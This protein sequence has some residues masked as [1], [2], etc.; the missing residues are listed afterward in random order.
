MSGSRPSV[1]IRISA[2]GAEQA[3]RQIEAIGPAG[4]A[5]MRRVATATS[6]ATPPVQNLARASDAATRALAGMGGSLGTLGGAL[7]GAT[8]AA[9]G[10]ST[11]LFAVGAAAATGLTAAIQVAEK[12]ERLSL[13]TEAIVRATGGAAGVS[14]TEIRT[15]SQ[16][17]A[18][19][20]LASTAGVEE[21]A[22]KLL[23]F[24]NVAGQTFE[25][26]LKAAQDLAAVGFG[27]IESASVQLG[28]AL[29]N[30]AEGLSA[31]TRIGVSFSGAQKEVIEQLVA[32]G[33]AAEA[34]AV[35][36]EAVEKQVGGAGNAEAGGLAGAYDTLGQN[37]QEFLLI[38]GNTG[39]LQAA[40][41]A[42]NILAGAIGA[43]NKAVGPETAL[44][45]AERGSAVA[46]EQAA[47]LR[48]RMQAAE[49]DVRMYMSSGLTREQAIS[50]AAPTAPGDMSGGLAKQLAEAE[51]AVVE[52]NQRLFEARQEH[53]DRMMLADERARA[54]AL[55]RDRDAA[56]SAL[57]QHRLRHDKEFAAKQAHEKE[58]AALNEWRRTG[59][60][61][62][63]EFTQMEAEAN[64]RL[65][66]AL[67]GTARAH[68]RVA[69]EAADA[70]AHVKT[71]LKAQEKAAE[72]VAKAQ[73][74]AAREIERFHERSFDA[75]ASIGE[76]AMDRLGDAMVDAF[77]KG[78]GAA[79]NFGNVARSIAA[80]V[81]TDFAKLALINPMLNS[82]FVSSSGARPTL[83]GAFGGG[84][85]SIG[86]IG[87]ML[88]LSGLLP[89]GGLGGM[90]ASANSYLFGT[91]AGPLAEVT[92]GLLGS[93]GSMSLGALGAGFGSGMFVNS[94]LGGNQVGGAV[95]SGLGSAAG[96]ALGSLVGMPFL[97]ALLG[98]GLGGGLGGMIGPKPSV[99]AWGYWLESQDGQLA[100]INRQYY[101]EAGAQQFAYA[102]QQ[103]AAT[104]AMLQA[105]GL[106]VSGSRNVGGNKNGPDGRWG[107]AGSFEEA[108]ADLRFSATD[109]AHLDS[110]L[111][112]RS[113]AGAQALAEFVEGFRAIE[114]VIKGLTSD[115]IPGFTA[116]I[117]AVNDNFAA[118][119]EEATRLGA[120]MDGL[121][122]AQLRAITEIEDART[123][124][125]RSSVMSLEVRRMRA[126]GETEQ[127]ELLAQ[128]EAANA[129]IRSFT[130]SLDSLA[131][132]AEDKAN[133]LLQL[134][135][136]Q[137]AE[138]AAI[139]AR[140]GEQAN[141]ALRRGLQSGES[142]M[143][144]LAFGAAS[145]LA[146]EQQYFAAMTTLNQARQALESGGSLSDYTTIASQVLPVA[147]DYLGTSQ[148]YGGLVSEI[149]Q[150]LARNGA[151]GAGLS[152]I[153]TAQVQSTDAMGATLAALGSRQVDELVELRREVG[154]LGSA[155]EALISRRQAA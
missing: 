95:G 84:A 111:S 106:T 124:M 4:D 91:T 98:G 90:M 147:R 42:I 122:D 69:K 133:R 82:L 79:V 114:A 107:G 10:L 56:D 148:R 116:S 65:A 125:L 146:P 85:T 62:A 8:T 70:D 68:A 76:R 117:N 123:E 26:T 94:L 59:A 46:T 16:E 51:K 63:A 2:E 129:E 131:I 109:N 74:K 40:T 57:R 121:A 128:T 139:V 24:R 54:A 104:N 119:R 115:A 47:R 30:P 41:A 143:R 66:K 75:V 1:G 86:G 28:K 81:V 149:G 153:L 97:G 132:E 150:V 53:I 11:A 155:L 25:R 100:P 31:L 105:S 3:R 23:T 15:L 83:A 72:A 27:S 127:A 88:G 113:F 118:V 71:Y 60:I 99:N 120:S 55:E 7:S 92:P 96:M 89:S 152:Q 140:W 48:T 18:R 67:D 36:L 110:A 87:Q 22:Q 144:E 43:L 93:G 5:A 35:I 39:P 101:N 6:A 102:D 142:L 112:G 138:R 58:M 29:E 103:V 34:Q 49:S 13:R 134:E 33:R 154:R 137:A 44:A 73:E 45:V 32:T 141:S 126:I 37:V 21:A 78:Q 12:F 17:I 64:E 151:D 38:V 9:A 77:L 61:N 145:P 136:V 20:T 19:S 14:A 52:A 130:A 50:L 135:E 108:F 80:S